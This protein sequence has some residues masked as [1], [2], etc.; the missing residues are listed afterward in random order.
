MAECLLAAWILTDERHL[1]RV[2]AVMYLEVAGV[3][4]GPLAGGHLAHEGFLSRMCAV[5]RTQ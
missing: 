1:A 5:V 2:D 3:A 4:E